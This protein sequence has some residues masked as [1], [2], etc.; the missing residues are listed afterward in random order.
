MA[1]DIKIDKK[2]LE[3]CHDAEGVVVV[4]DVLRAFTTTAHAFDRG[5]EEILLVSTVDEAF[6]LRRQQPDLLLMGELDGYPVEGFDLPNSPS[7]IA[8]L[9]L[10]HRRLVLRTTAGSQGAVLAAHAKD[11]Y[12][13]SFS[14]ATSTALSIARHHPKVVTFIE[15]GLTSKGG[16]EEDTACA[17]YIASLLLKAPLDKSDIEKRVI[18]SEAAFKFS[19]SEGDSFPRSDLTQALKIDQFNFSMKVTRVNEHLVLKPSD[20]NIL[21]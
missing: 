14:V 9:D 20:V 10:S 21:E 5:A 4:V 17:D 7:A 16:G 12:V 11:M 19:D 15:T 2:T 6:E 3:T 8:K 13:A 18:S 1:S